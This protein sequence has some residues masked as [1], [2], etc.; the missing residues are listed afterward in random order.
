MQT[1]TSH[2]CRLASIL[3]LDKMLESFAHTHTQTCVRAR[4]HERMH[5]HCRNLKEPTW[6]TF[7]SLPVHSIS[8]S[9]R[10]PGLHEILVLEMPQDPELPQGALGSRCAGK[11]VRIVWGLGLPIQ[12]PHRY[13]ARMQTAFWANMCRPATLLSQVALIVYS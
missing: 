3:D 4:N 8:Q 13:F 10:S 5:A 12:L 11:Q 6:M 9:I 2:P 7:A 1:D